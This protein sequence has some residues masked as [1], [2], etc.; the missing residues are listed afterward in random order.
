[1]SQNIATAASLGAPRRL[2][3]ETAAPQ[4]PPASDTNGAIPG[5]VGTSQ[6]ARFGESEWEAK[7]RQRE[8][9]QAQAR[10]SQIEKTVQWWSSCS[11]TWREKYSQVRT[12]R[13]KA[14]DE[15]KQLRS[16]LEAAIK[17][18]NI[19]KKEK[20]ELELQISQL[21]KEMEKIHS[22]LMKHAG[23]FEKS[24][25]EGI[26]EP[27]RCGRDNDSPDVSSDGLKNVNSE[28]G[29][30]NK[31]DRSQSR[32]SDIEGCMLQEPISKILECEQNDDASAE[33]RRLIQ[34]L[35]KD[36]N[37]EDEYLQQKI[38]TL[39]LRLDDAH[40]TLEKERE[41]KHNYMKN[42]E[43]LTM[44]MQEVQAQC[45]EL[46][47]SKQDAVRELLTLQEQHRAE[48]RI[49]N[50][51][52]Q[53]EVNARESLERR[54]CELRGELERMQAENAA[55]WGRRE[56]LETEKL[57]LE[58]DN[59]K[60]RCELRDFQELAD[61][62]GRPLVSSDIEIRNL[63]QELAERNK[64]IFDFKHSHG[65][66]KKLL[67][68]SNTELGHAVRRAEQYENEV[69]RLRA[70]VE[71]LK[72]ELV[73][74]ED[75]LDAACNHVKR[76]Q[77]TKEEAG[78]GEGF[79]LTS[80]PKHQAYYNSSYKPNINDLRQLFDDTKRMNDRGI[81][82]SK[83]QLMEAK[84]QLT[85]QSLCYDV[86]GSLGECEGMTEG[87]QKFDFERAKQKFDKN[88]K[89]TGGK[90]GSSG[91]SRSSSLSGKKLTESYN[92]ELGISK[93]NFNETVQFFDENMRK[94]DGYMKTSL[95]LDGLKISDDEVS[96]GDL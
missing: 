28:D 29:L 92:M 69:K 60:L 57:I 7:E 24:G 78:G 25:L 8:L 88:G 5:G 86:K 20:S 63:Q 22:L 55:E 51:A 19:Y 1:M 46:R 35:S 39:R 91:G 70:R 81:F 77:R 52:L 54:L 82:P 37:D 66:L 6:S 36:D 93:Q 72:R 58:R 75:E 32:D 80:S 68:E 83:S 67:A 23:Q 62:R 79:H 96:K 31:T 40:K 71:E 76:L 13:N 89:V 48:V 9:E 11:K 42:I 49:S 85:P 65:K 16:S 94:K 12:E 4:A 33:E 44:E 41:E 61:R 26:D 45:E 56:R 90:G 17:E 84:G 95:N 2:R 14:R 38:S 74:V 3:G 27:E 73:R 53:D 30:V 10:V 21:K 34:Q 64:E 87:R 18:S 50:N 59:K 15:A 47:L 43:R